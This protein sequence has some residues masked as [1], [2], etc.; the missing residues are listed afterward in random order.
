[1]LL[2]LNKIFFSIKKKIMSSYNKLLLD[3]F[4]F[5]L[6]DVIYNKNLDKN[7]A[8]YASLKLPAVPLYP[9]TF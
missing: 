6:T 2:D 5:S 3:V 8:D 7:F 4:H 9:F 1:M